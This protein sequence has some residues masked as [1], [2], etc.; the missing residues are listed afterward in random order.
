MGIKRLDAAHRMGVLPTPQAVAWQRGF[1]KGRPRGVGPW[2]SERSA[3]MKTAIQNVKSGG[4]EGSETS[5][6]K[7]NASALQSPFKAMS[8]AVRAE[9]LRQLADDRL[10]H[11]AMFR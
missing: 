4:R 1:L 6:K 8:T 9:T 11:F 3:Q 10:R 5:M 7:P 2:T